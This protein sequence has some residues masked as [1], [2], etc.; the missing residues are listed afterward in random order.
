MSELWFIINQCS[1][2]LT[3]YYKRHFEPS[4]KSWPIQ[5][6]IHEN[7]FSYLFGLLGLSGLVM[8]AARF[9]ESDKKLVKDANAVCFQR[10]IAKLL[11]TR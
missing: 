7:A 6:T 8:M 2:K 3:L 4:P 11:F 9:L 1:A 10:K 5:H